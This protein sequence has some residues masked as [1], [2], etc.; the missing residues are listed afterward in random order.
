MGSA[1]SQLKS[2]RRFVKTSAHPEFALEFW[3]VVRKAVAS[4]CLLGVC[5]MLSAAQNWAISLSSCVNAL[6]FGAGSAGVGGAV[7]AANGNS[8]LVL[9]CF[10]LPGI[11]MKNSLR[12]DCNW[13]NVYRI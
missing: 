8:E 11:Q 4:P 10:H 6:M 12:I 13:Q 1:T 3:L 5:A 7:E 9:V 2:L